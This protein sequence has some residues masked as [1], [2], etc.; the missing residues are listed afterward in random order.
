MPEI[1]GQENKKPIVD[2][3][4]PLEIPKD[5][6][7]K[8]KQVK[9]VILGD[10]TQQ[11]Y[12]AET[13][14]LG[15]F[16]GKLGAIDKEGASPYLTRYLPK[17]K[18]DY[19]TK[20]I[21][22]SAFEKENTIASGIADTINGTTFSNIA[23][24]NFNSADYVYDNIRNTK[25]ETHF[26]KFLGLRN[27]EDAIKLQK[28]IDRE[29]QNN[30]IIA[31]SGWNGWTASLVA[32]ISDPINFIPVG[33]T[34][35]KSIKAG[36]TLA[37][38]TKTAIAGAG[39]VA[40][41]E[42]ILQSQQETRT[43]QESIVNIAGGTILGG[44]LGGA[45]A[46]L[47]KKKFNLISKK[48]EQDLNDVDFKIKVD[49]ETEK[50]QINP[51]AEKSVGAMEN[52]K[53][54]KKFYNDVYVKQ[55][56]EAGKTP[57]SF[58]EFSIKAEGLA[59]VLGGET[60]TKLIEKISNVPVIGKTTQKLI[61]SVA[62]LDRISPNLRIL[63]A[64]YSSKAK[65][66]LQKLTTT[67]MTTFKNEL[68]IANQQSVWI[69]RKQLV[70]PFE[71]EALPAVNDIYKKYIDRVKKEGGEVKNRADFEKEIVRAMNYNDVSD[72]PEVSQS[73]TIYRK[74]V[75]EPLGKTAERMGIVK[76]KQFKPNEFGL[77]QSYFPQSWNRVQVVAKEDKLRNILKDKIKNKIIPSIKNA[78][79]KK[80]RD[81]I[82]QVGDLMNEKVKLQDVIDKMEVELKSKITDEE[83]DILDRYKKAKKIFADKKPKSLLQWIRENGGIFDIGGELRAMDISNKNYPALLRKDL[84]NKNHPDD[85]AL[86]A[87]ENGYFVGNERPDM[88]DLFDLIDREVRGEKIY[89]AKDQAL[90]D[91]IE[92]ANNFFDTL[93]E[94]GI[95]IKAIEEKS[96]LRIKLIDQEKIRKLLVKKEI[97]LIQKRIDRLDERFKNDKIDFNSKFEEAGDINNYIE[98]TVDDILANLKQERYG[99]SFADFTIN[100]R[101]PLKRRAL[102][103]LEY[104]EI[105]DFLKTDATEI[106]RNYARIMSTDIELA[107]NFD[108]DLTLKNELDN[109]ADEYTM[110][111]KEAKT[112]EERNKIDKEKKRVIADIEALRD[113]LRGNYGNPEDPDSILTRTFQASRKLNFLQKMGGVVISSFSDVANP[114]AI[115][116]FKRWVPALQN[117]IT[118]IQG[119]KLNVEE[120]KLAGNII[121][122]TTLGRLNSMA[123]IGDPFHSNRSAFE[124]L[125][126]NGVKLMSK[127][128]LM[129]LWNDA[130]KSFAGVISQQRIINESRNWLNGNIKQNDRTY[131]SFLGIGE[132]EAKDIIEQVDK[133]GYK[134][135]NLWVANTKQWENSDAKFVFRNA[136]NT[137][138][139]RTIVSLGA[140]D[141]PLFMNKEVGKTIGQFKSFAFAST[142]QVLIARL[143]QKDMAA[144][145]GFISAVSLGMLTYYLKTIG[146]GKE[147]SQDPNK[148]I[149]EGIDRSG[150]LGVMMEVNNITEKLTGGAVGVN[151][152]IDGE[153]MS[154]Y[155]S[156]NIASTLI[157]PTAGQIQDIAKITASI[158]NG[159]IT[160][161]DVKAFRRTLPYQNLF[162]L[163]GAFD[164][165]EQSLNETIGQ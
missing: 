3:T 158:S 52:I 103:F 80:E 24:P 66:V 10:A 42:G 19:T 90:I 139:D 128:N 94:M 138:I 140:G 121:E 81:F 22:K 71:N 83:L 118:N 134:D 95:D 115:H 31:S 141:I 112:L 93:D 58:K 29:E 34:A 45:G 78:F 43:A 161:S 26:E 72:I 8:T 144:L 149:V 17:E 51:I 53:E 160:E 46:L 117:L 135:G 41:T 157:G 119:I 97:D 28:R 98:D 153:N 79:A 91:E 25:Y 165:L 99:N 122:K 133:F 14:L 146:A 107:R 154:R 57:L 23:D 111:T 145:Q 62:K 109:I 152:L 27:E 124:R 132:Q 142:Q 15:G 105:A 159:E 64:K 96:L 56:I 101:G 38:I 100:K 74:N 113:I 48:L 55:E 4:K 63:N 136:L 12:S 156:R 86:R 69:S 11:P 84:T 88:N 131:L 104:D 130:N 21:Y 126:D 147:P 116:G 59:P 155:A 148:W 6:P 2:F 150:Y 123:E 36:K 13:L 50:T 5:R 35:Y 33:G 18:A 151:A 129:P 162:Y 68:G 20:Q 92:Y 39:G 67:G 127:I 164:E 40:L 30:E 85:V 16:G 89:S 44:V 163:K 106:V 61:K 49:P 102:D 60:A 47:S 108:N 114:I 143:Q 7:I 82:S 125:L 70:A 37:S 1:P 120:A 76:L 77:N 32:G 87:W 9:E 137:D 65:E 110:A 73:A 75:L 54:V